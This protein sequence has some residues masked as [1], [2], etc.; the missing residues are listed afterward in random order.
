MQLA[1]SIKSSKSFFT[2]FSFIFLMLID[3]IIKNIVTLIFIK[4]RCSNSR[5]SYKIILHNLGK[6]PK[7]PAS[8]PFFCNPRS[9]C[10]RLITAGDDTKSAHN[11]G[12]T[13]TRRCWCNNHGRNPRTPRRIHL[14]SRGDTRTY[15]RMM[16]CT[17]SQTAG[18]SPT[19][20]MKHTPRRGWKQP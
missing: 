5:S 11:Y 13:D 7:C 12:S 6:W 8:S 10:S 15:I 9:G 3:I 1:S 20:I 2:N 18:T 16:A 17:P 19:S 4:R 14:R